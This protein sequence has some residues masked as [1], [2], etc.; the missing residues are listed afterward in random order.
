M[1][2]LFPRVEFDPCESVQS[3]VARSA[4]FHIGKASTPFLRDIGITPMKLVSGEPEALERLSAVT[5]TDLAAIVGNTAVRVGKRRYNLRGNILPAEFFT[6]PCTAYCPACLKEDDAIGAP[7]ALVRRH[8]WL[9]ALDVVRTCPEHRLPLVR[10]VKKGHE[11]ELHELG[12]R[13]PAPGAA[14]DADIAGLEPR[15]VSP[16]QAYVVGRLEGKVGP[17]WLDAQGLDQVVRATQLLGTA[18]A[19]GVQKSL[20]TMTDGERERAATVGYGYMERGEAGVQEALEQV[21]AGF[22]GEGSN[23]GLHKI[24]GRLYTSMSSIEAEA[25]YGDVARLL[26]ELIF[27]RVALPSG[28]Q[29]LGEVLPER[30][31]HTVASLAAEAKLDS[32]ALRQ[33]LIARGLLEADDPPYVTISAEEGRAV[34]AAIGRAI[35]AIK[36]PE[37]LGCS[38]QLVDQLIDERLLVSLAESHPLASGGGCKSV[39]ADHVQEFLEGVRAVSMVADEV[40]AGLVPITAA[41]EKASR[42]AVEIVHLILGGYLAR[43][44]RVD[45]GE[46]L[47]AIRVDPIEVKAVVHEVMVG[48]S[49]ADAFGILRIPN[50]AGWALVDCDELPAISIA[51]PNA[52]HRFFRF[53]REDVDAVAARLVTAARI[54]QPIG[55]SARDV[56]RHMRQNRVQPEFSKA[57]IG[58][59]LYTAADAERVLLT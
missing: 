45:G 2:A 23:G 25:R 21:Y 54:G 18:L 9:W 36:L 20:A 37:A 17:A 55:R 40:P 44:F 58:I 33:V 6:R 30:R 10:L 29:I 8:R 11:D 32:R 22:K 59:N 48:L 4:A 27:E 34:A 57:N 51:A 52:A 12:K 46:G 47:S 39:A 31:R 28:A 50:G 24:F 38:R 56:E 5:G 14:I 15:Q 49:P 16:L 7:A 19:F 43:V 1:K 42:P 35:T 26:R 53:R 41:S 13:A 3:F